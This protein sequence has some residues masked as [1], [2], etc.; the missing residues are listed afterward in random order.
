[1]ERLRMKLE[2]YVTKLPAGT[3]IFFLLSAWALIFRM[4]GFDQVFF[5]V[6]LLL[7]VC[8]PGMYHGGASRGVSAYSIFNRGQ[9]HL[10]GDLRVEQIEAEQRGD[11]HLVNY[12]AGGGLIELDSLGED[13]FS[14]DEVPLVKSRDGNRPCKCGSG[15]KAKKCCYAPPRRVEEV[16]QRKAAARVDEPDPA[17]DRWRAEMEVVQ[18]GEA[19]PHGRR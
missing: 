4:T 17:L 14:E 6:S 8:G 2:P 19:R 10:L 3:G 12:N 5:M 13:S 1:M 7:L 15:K 11:R 16:K 9:Q 18:A